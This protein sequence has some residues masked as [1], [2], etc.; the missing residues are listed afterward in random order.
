MKSMSY[1][2][3]N[4]SHTKNTL[5]PI[6]F[7]NIDSIEDWVTEELTLLDGED[8]GWEIVEPPLELEALPLEDTEPHFDDDVDDILP[9]ENQSQYQW[10][11]GDNYY[12]GDQD[13]YHYVE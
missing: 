9:N 2:C 10:G 1:I 11:D 4:I 6:S 8:V 5:D 13:P 7:D 3:R 12:G